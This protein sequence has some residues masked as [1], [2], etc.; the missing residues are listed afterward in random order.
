MIIFGPLK[1]RRVSAKRRHCI[2]S[3]FVGGTHWV[4]RIMLVHDAAQL[5]RIFYPT[6]GP[7]PRLWGGVTRPCDWPFSMII[8]GLLRTRRVSAKTRHCINSEFVGATRWV[9]RIMLVHDAAQLAPIFYPTPG[10]SPRLWG[11]VTRPCDWLDCTAI[12]GPLRVW[13]PAVET[14][15]GKGDSQSRPYMV[16]PVLR[17]ILRYNR[18]NTETLR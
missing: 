3:E 13:K 4:A 11:G 12:L 17:V 18:N 5:A 10:P 6:P 2:N 16:C 1:T 8:F 14:R 15:C 9:A 7:S